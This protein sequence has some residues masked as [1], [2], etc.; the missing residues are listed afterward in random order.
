M[1][2]SE[3]GN[4]QQEVIESILFWARDLNSQINM[5]QFLVSQEIK[6]G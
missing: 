4:G 5:C 3:M 1:L 2:T 6:G